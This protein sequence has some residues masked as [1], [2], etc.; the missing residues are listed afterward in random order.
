MVK[1]KFTLAARAQTGVEVWLF[2]FF[3]LSGRWGV[4]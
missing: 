2:S 4:G 1:V 3:N